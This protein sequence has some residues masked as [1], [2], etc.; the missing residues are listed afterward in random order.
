MF[1]LTTSRRGR[2]AGAIC[3]KKI[4]VRF[5]SRPHEEV[6]LCRIDN[7]TCRCVSTH[8]L[9][10]RSTFLSFLTSCNSSRFN[11]RPHEE[12]DD[13]A[14]LSTDVSSLFQLTTSRR[15]RRLLHPLHLQYLCFNSRPHEEVDLHCHQVIILIDR[16]NSRPHEEVDDILF[17]VFL[18]LHVSTHDLTKRSTHMIR[19]LILCQ[20]CFNSRPHEEV[21]VRGS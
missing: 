17:F 20:H 21:D 8:D 6:D 19:L 1:Q 11:S 10:K 2:P 13:Y 4:L 3:N 12:V 9:T 16:F 7:Y 14:Q 15:G 5:N 18:R